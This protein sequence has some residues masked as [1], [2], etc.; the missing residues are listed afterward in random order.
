M[1]DALYESAGIVSTQDLCDLQ[2]QH[3]LIN[4]TGM[5]MYGSNR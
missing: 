4:Y 2:T 3:M 1:R 5:F